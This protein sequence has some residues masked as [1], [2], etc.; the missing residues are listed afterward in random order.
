[1]SE[2][3]EN[4]FDKLLTQEEAFLLHGGKRVKKE[5]TM[6]GRY[7]TPA[8][9]T[10]MPAEDD[11]LYVDQALPILSIH[12]VATLDDIIADLEKGFAAVK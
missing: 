11:T 9:F 7:Y 8:I 4:R 1:M 10:S 12:T 2:D 6:N 3:A 5:Y